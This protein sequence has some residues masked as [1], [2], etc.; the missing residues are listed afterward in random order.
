MRD[1]FQKAPAQEHQTNPSITVVMSTQ[2]SNEVYLQIVPVLMSS[3]TGKREKTYALLD[4]GS[5]STLIREDFVA[6]LKVHRNKT[7][8]K[9]NSIKDQGDS[10]LLHEVDLRNSSIINNI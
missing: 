6:E 1:A 5:Q 9:I 8:I 7:K 4:I 10:I 3:L 2:E